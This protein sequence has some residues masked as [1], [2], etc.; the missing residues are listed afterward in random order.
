MIITEQMN[1]R[2]EWKKNPEVIPVDWDSSTELPSFIKEAK[3]VERRKKIGIIPK[4]DEL[5]NG[6]FLKDFDTEKY[7]FPQIL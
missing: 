3:E 5:F 2:K 7:V 1:V 6:R 4:I